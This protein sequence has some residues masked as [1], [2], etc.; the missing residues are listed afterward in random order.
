MFPAIKTAGSTDADN[1]QFIVTGIGMQTKDI[2]YIIP[3]T[4]P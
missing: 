1:T 3:A 2:G 4:Y